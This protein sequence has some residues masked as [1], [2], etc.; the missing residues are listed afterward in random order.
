M[1]YLVT[2]FSAKSFSSEGLRR[3]KIDLLR[4]KGPEDLYFFACIYVNVKASANHCVSVYGLVYPCVTFS[5]PFRGFAST[6]IE[7]GWAHQLVHSY[8][9]SRK[10]WGSMYI[11]A[12]IVTHCKACLGEIEQCNYNVSLLAL[13]WSLR[14]LGVKMWEEKFT[15]AEQ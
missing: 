10:G 13:L 9:D 4:L 3:K 12:W 2:L 6:I 5:N 1:S 11:F 8:G 15:K 14:N 7:I